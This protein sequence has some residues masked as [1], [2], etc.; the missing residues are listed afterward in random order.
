MSTVRFLADHDLND[1][2]VTGIRRRELAIE[3]LRVRELGFHTRSDSGLLDFAN[4]E[5]LLVVSHDVNT[6]TAAASQRLAESRGIAGL[7]M[8]PQSMP[9]NE[10]IESLL[11]IWSATESN[12]WRDQI[13]FL[14]L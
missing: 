3:F 12:D 5:H 11:L 8:I 1:H 14:P 9:V 4:Q 13:V 6:M 7:L 10:V 2:I